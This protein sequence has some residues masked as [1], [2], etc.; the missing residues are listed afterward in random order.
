M[1][2]QLERISGIEL[3]V[4]LSVA[5]CIRLFTVTTSRSIFFLL[6]RFSILFAVINYSEFYC[7]SSSIYRRARRGFK[8]LKYKCGASDTGL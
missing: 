4:T 1:F 3:W 8:A 7:L 2:V 6:P 5:E